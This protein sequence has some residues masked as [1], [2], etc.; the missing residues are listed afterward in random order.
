MDIEQLYK[1]QEQIANA[2][3]AGFILELNKKGGDKNFDKIL[4]GIVLPTLID[5]FFEN[6]ISDDLAPFYSEMLKKRIDKLVT[7]S[8]KT[9]TN[10]AFIT[11]ELVQTLFK[12]DVSTLELMKEYMTMH[13]KILRNINPFELIPEI[14][15]MTGQFKDPIEIKKEMQR[16]VDEKLSKWAEK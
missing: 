16:R 14:L 10:P 11:E 15:E 1:E 7:S 3:M 12:Q 9:N 6:Y 2:A 8:K 5:I 4:G 13:P